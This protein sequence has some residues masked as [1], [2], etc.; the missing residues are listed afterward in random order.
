MDFRSHLVR[1]MDMRV[2]SNVVLI[3]LLVIAAGVA[4]VLWLS[5]G[6]VELL[7][8]PVFTFV[9]WALVREI[10]PDHE[11]AAALAGL[12]AGAW[13]LI[14]APVLSVWAVA[15]LAVAARIVSGT[16]GRRLLPVDLV[17]VAALGT[18]I[19]L[20]VEGWVAGFGIALALYLDDRFR[21][22]SRLSVIAA[23]ALT[24]AGTTI[25]ASSSDAF[26]ETLPGVIQYVVI[27]AGVAALILLFR[28]PATP[29]SQVDAR[30]AAFLDRTRLH[31]SRTVVGV[32]AFVMAI[33]AG[34]SGQGVIVVIGALVVVIIS[35]EVELLRRRTG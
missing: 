31:I 7:L 15:G 28:E 26:P 6:P 35:N 16:T 9:I 19:G 24:A 1:P 34:T 18:F 3:V 11:W 22:E 5:R 32:Q 12:I 20:T 30:H 4:L 10:D 33:L 13:V 21:D 25:V 17:A 14:G 23:S 8:A 27:A 2:R 29:I